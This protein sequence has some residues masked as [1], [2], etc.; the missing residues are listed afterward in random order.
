MPDAGAGATV[1]CFYAIE[2]PASVRVSLGA[3]Q[4]HLARAA[5]GAVRW[6]PAANLHLTLVFLGD[7]AGDLLGPLARVADGAA[8]GGAPFTLRAGGLGYFGPARV[9]RVLWA[10][11]AGAP[12]ALTRLRQALADGAAAATGAPEEARPYH[13]HITLGRLRPGRPAHGLTSRVESHK[14][15]RYGVFDVRRVVLL[16]SRIRPEGTVYTPLHEALL[17]GA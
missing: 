14:S 16:R 5:P 6:V 15:A 3:A 10:G 4:K 11:V 13:P 12:T 2:L 9:P 7:V 1:R 17:G 8:R